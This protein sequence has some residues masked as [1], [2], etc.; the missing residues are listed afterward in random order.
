MVPDFPLKEEIDLIN[1]GYQND[2]FRFNLI[3][4]RALYPGDLEVLSSLAQGT[5][6]DCYGGNRCRDRPDRIEPLTL[7]GLS[8]EDICERTLDAHI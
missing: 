4:S 2:S 6:E 5:H 8:V 7:A 1:L 3:V